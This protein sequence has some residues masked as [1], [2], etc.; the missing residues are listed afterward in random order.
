MGFSGRCC[1]RLRGIAGGL[2]RARGASLRA[3][4]LALTQ[5]TGTGAEV[6]RR[7]AQ[8]LAENALL[9][10][11]LLVLRRRVRRPVVTAADRALLV[12]LAGRV[13]AW[14][15]ALLLVRP[16]TLLRWHRAGFRSC[17]RWQSRPG[18][19]R[20]PL[21][22]ETIALLR[23]LATAN[24]RWGA[25]RS[26]GAR[27]KLG[28]RVAQR[29]KPDLSAR[30]PRAAPARANVGHLPAQPRPRQLGVR[31]PPG[32]GPA[33]PAAVRLLRRRTGHAARRP[34][35]RDAPA[36]QRLGRPAA[37]R[38]HPCGQRPRHPIR[39]NDGKCGPAFARVA[40]HRRMPCAHGSAGACVARASTTCSSAVRGSGP[41]CSARTWRPATGYG[42]IRASGRAAR[43]RHRRSWR[44]M[45][46]R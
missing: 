34:R 15:Q 5:A 21:P 37:A 4:P 16:A 29:T 31:L 2:R 26:R 10:Q 36:D 3:R 40:R 18:P 33:L 45:P 17:W 20:P 8:L 6:V 9:R 38:G 25:E 14:R 39:D 42:R 44:A 19:G 22:A 30:P 11:Q 28:S 7:R 35:G 23:R 1:R 46:I 32:H 27:G 43:R 13:R 24:P 12:V 41:A